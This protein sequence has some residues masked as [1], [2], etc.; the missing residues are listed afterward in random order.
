MKNVRSVFR[1]LVCGCLVGGVALFS[2]AGCGTGPRS[3]QPGSAH[4]HGDHHHD[5]D[6]DHG[7]ATPEDFAAGVATLR[8]HF[9]TI[10]DALTENDVDTA[11]APSTRSPTFLSGFVSRL[12]KRGWAPRI[13]RR[14]RARSPRCSRD[15]RRSTRRSTEMA[16]S[17]TMRS[18]TNWIKAWPNWKP[19]PNVP[20]QRR[21]VFRSRSLPRPFRS[22]PVLH[23]LHRW[24]PGLETSPRGPV[25]PCP[26]LSPS[27]ACLH[28][29]RAGGCG[30]SHSPNRNRQREPSPPWRR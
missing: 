4:Q 15:T 6:H 2:L 17:I 16:T 29:C 13:W 24:E 10:R 21:S 26:P 11:H 23:V 9:E 18:A 20:R 22:P 30:V 14:P 19:S 12:L 3:D 5:H 1:R 7:H 8:G 25:S 27:F 28:G